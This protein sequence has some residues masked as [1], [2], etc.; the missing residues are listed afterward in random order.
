MSK[1]SIKTV[2][3]ANS[4][5][6]IEHIRTSVFIKEQHVPVELEWD[7]FDNDSAHILAYYDNKPVG[8][9][10][11]L[12]DGHIGRMSVLKE[13]GNRK[14]GENMLKYMLAMAQECS[15][16]TIKLSAQEHAVGFYKKYGFT[17]TS[18]RYLDAEIPHYNMQ[19]L[20]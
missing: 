15:I 9:A 17:V 11:L 2:N 7:E 10:R 1:I 16:M 19:Y 3:F 5:T 8:T 4:F 20:G 13:Y 6:D 12:K 14:I 18:D